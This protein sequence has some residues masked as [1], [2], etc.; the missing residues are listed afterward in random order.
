MIPI[1]FE[2]NHCLVVNKPAGLLAQGDITGDESLVD[3]AKTYLK[4]TYA[5]PGEVYLGLVHRLDRQTSGVILLARTSK[6]AG[7]LSEQ[8]RR[9]EIEKTYWAIVEGSIDGDDGSFH[10]YLLKDPTTNHVEALEGPSPGSVEAILDYK[11]IDRV[12]RKCWL[13]LRPRTG[14]SHQL[15]VQLASRGLPI[16]GD[17]KYGATSVL[18]ASDGGY[19]IALHARS[20]KFGHPTKKEPVECSAPIWPDWPRWEGRATGLPV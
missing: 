5:K 17:R 12:G 9:G 10:D 15:R 16:F 2:D 14:R 3:I 19:R 4:T 8:F 6:A 18:G 20:L 11:V 7:R 13:E 1:L